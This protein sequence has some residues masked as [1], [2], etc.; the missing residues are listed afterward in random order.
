MRFVDGGSD[1][2]GKHGWGEGVKE[3]KGDAQF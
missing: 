2:G 1:S 3:L